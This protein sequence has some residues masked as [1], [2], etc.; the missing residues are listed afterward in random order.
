MASV[1]DQQRRMLTL[2]DGT[3]HLEQ[4]KV[5][6]LADLSFEY[7]SWVGHN[8]N[9][10]ASVEPIRFSAGAVFMIFRISDPQGVENIFE[11]FM[12]RTGLPGGGSDALDIAWIGRAALDYKRFDECLLEFFS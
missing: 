10:P 9:L 3:V 12:G 6:R 5:E 7:H 8:Y 11:Y 1:I 2:G 4:W